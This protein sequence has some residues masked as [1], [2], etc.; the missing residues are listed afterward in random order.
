MEKNYVVNDNTIEILN[1]SS[2]TTREYHNEKKIQLPYHIH[3]RKIVPNL[4]YANDHRAVVYSKENG[5]DNPTK[6]LL[7][8]KG[9]VKG[10]REERKKKQDENMKRV[11]EE[12]QKEEDEKVHTVN[13]MDLNDDEIDLNVYEIEMDKDDLKEFQEFKKLKNK[14]SEMKKEI[15]ISSEYITDSINM[16][17]IV[18]EEHKINN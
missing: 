3:S 12:K 15:Q 7:P 16:S 13:L 11:S 2:I 14:V 10:L 6:F 1:S 8:R 4:Y 18:E 9:W 17:I 5:A